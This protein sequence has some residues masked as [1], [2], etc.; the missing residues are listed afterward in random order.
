V[1]ALEDQ[2][3]TALTPG[4]VVGHSLPGGYEIHGAKQEALLRL[5]GNLPEVSRQALV[6]T[7]ISEG[8]DGVQLLAQVTA[9][10]KKEIIPPAVKAL[11]PWALLAV[12]V[13]AVVLGARYYLRTRRNGQSTWGQ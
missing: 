12:A 3:I 8:P 13:V 4:G 2:I 1:S 11:W 6:A 7:I 10:V 5:N 9:S